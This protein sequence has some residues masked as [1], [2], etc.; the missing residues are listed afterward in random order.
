MTLRLIKT[1]LPDED[2]GG[3]AE[4]DVALLTSDERYLGKGRVETTGGEVQLAELGNAPQWMKVFCRTL[5]RGAWRS[6]ADLGW[7]RRITRWREPPRDG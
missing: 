7:P 4:Y 3:Y 6:R 1:P 5:L 2:D